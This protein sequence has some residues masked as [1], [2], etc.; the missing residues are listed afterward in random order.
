MHTGCRSFAIKEVSP[1]TPERVAYFLADNCLQPSSLKVKQPAVVWHTDVRYLDKI[2]I[3]I[4]IRPFHSGSPCSLQQTGEVN[5]TSTLQGSSWVQSGLPAGGRAGCK[6]RSVQIKYPWQPLQAF[7]LS[8]NINLFTLWDLPTCPKWSLESPP[9]G[10]LSPHLMAGLSM[11]FLS[12]QEHRHRACDLSKHLRVY[13]HPTPAGSQY[14]SSPALERTG[15]SGASH[16]QPA[17]L[18][19]SH[20]PARFCHFEQDS[21][22]P[23]FGTWLNRMFPGHPEKMQQ[24]IHSFIQLMHPPTIWV[25]TGT[26]IYSWY[27]VI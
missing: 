8:P 4:Q 16:L 9:H 23:W 1:C 11:P 19:C 27:D 17:Q 5:F 24:K 3:V 10:G 22:L 6:L 2:A 15:G 21:L 26:F 25:A 7:V 20:N 14:L 12:R 13:V 18:P